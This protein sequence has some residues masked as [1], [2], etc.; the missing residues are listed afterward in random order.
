[1]DRP[2]WDQ[3][4]MDMASLAASRSTCLRRQVGAIAIKK[5]EGGE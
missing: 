5:A 2:S 1:M 4:F 3:Y